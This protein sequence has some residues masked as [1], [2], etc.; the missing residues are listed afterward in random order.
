MSPPSNGFDA[1]CTNAAFRR[2]NHTLAVYSVTRR[3]QFGFL[4]EKERIDSPSIRRTLLLSA[5][6]ARSSAGESNGFLIRGSGV[7]VTPG[8]HLFSTSKTPF[9]EG[10]S[11]S[12][13][14]LTV[15]NRRERK[16][17]KTPS[18]HQLFVK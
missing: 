8:A 13:V 1:R 10:Q 15:T 3:Q 2:Y 16:R 9:H 17:M 14:I 4:L 6:C 7:R 5:K 12:W 18:I 11:L